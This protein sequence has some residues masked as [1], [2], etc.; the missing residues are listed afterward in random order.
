MKKQIQANSLKINQ[1]ASAINLKKDP[2]PPPPAKNKIPTA[3]PNLSVSS[4]MSYANK[5]IYPG[6]STTNSLSSPADLI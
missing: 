2:P 5:I 1:P 6:T 4:A 3:V